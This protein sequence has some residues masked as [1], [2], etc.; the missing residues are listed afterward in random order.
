MESFL[1]NNDYFSLPEFENLVNSG[2]K[3]S[4]SDSVSEKVHACFQYLQEKITKSDAL[5]YGVN[6][7]FGSLCNTKISAL[8]LT[9]L[10]ENLIRSHA[11]GLGER[12]P[13]FLV[14]RMLLLKVIGLVKRYP[15]H[16]RLC[17]LH[18][19]Y[20]QI[21]FPFWTESSGPFFRSVRWQTECFS[22]QCK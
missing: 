22:I 19:H 13:D 10:Q 1:L 21:A 9:K 4:L 5:I 18:C 8:D 3:I 7:G 12:V 15:V 2:Q 14:K 11:C 20:S 6:T 17:L 16:E